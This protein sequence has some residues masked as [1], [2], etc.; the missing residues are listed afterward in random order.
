MG[1]T[2][3]EE[4]VLSSRGIAGHA[5]IRFESHQAVVQGGVLFL[6]PA[7]ISQQLLKTKE[8]YQLPPNH[9]YGLESVILTLAFMALSRIKNPEQLKQCKPGELGRLIGLDRTPEVK[10][11]RNKIKLLADQKQA[12]ELNRQLIDQWYKNTP[13]EGTFLYIDG[14]QRIYYGSKANLPSKYISRQKL[15]LAATTEYWVHDA[16]GQPVMMVM[17]ELTEK[18]EQVIGDQ[19]IPELQKTV[20]LATNPQAEDKQTPSDGPIQTQPACTLIFDREGYHPAF[21]KKLWDKYRIAVITYRKHVQDKWT[22][23]DFI[24]TDVTVLD[25]SVNMDICEKEVFLDGMRFR[26][27]RKKSEDGHQISII[28]TN[29]MIET[30]VIAGR[31]FGRWVQ[32]NFFK[33]LIADFDFDKMI[34]YG[35]Q[36]VDETREIINPLWR[37]ADYK[38]KK[39]K[40]KTA[41]LKAK[42]YPIAE[43]VMN[44]TIDNM[45]SLTQKHI[46]LKEK[47]EASEKLEEELLQKRSELQSR[48]KVNQMDEK[49]KYNRLKWESKMFLNIIKMICYRSET[50]VANLLAEHLPGYWKDRKRMLV[51][52]IIGTNADLIVDGDQKTLTVVL[53]S[54]SARRYNEA[55]K[56]LADLLNETQTVFP[57]SEMRVI[58]KTS[59]I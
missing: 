26:E 22:E 38:L 47:I 11:L 42:L 39:Q 15:C 32:E 23:E 49:Q 56:K 3:F 40:E 53:H 58:F 20:L 16:I 5:S 10:C 52:Q 46:K 27:V 21:F 28:T 12:R 37:K 44:Q 33:Y 50:A 59:A 43:Q 35:T 41:R 1:T 4:R 18:L 6:L 25:Q 30:P 34:T 7:L 17:G 8:L 13:E 36:P 24:S 29:Y 2:R 9:Y 54:L 57:G 19:I 48:I 31:M 45:P 55:A 51:K 14:H